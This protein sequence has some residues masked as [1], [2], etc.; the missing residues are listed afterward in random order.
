MILS[1]AGGMLG[2]AIGLT[3]AG[4][5]F[6]LGVMLA[7]AGAIVNA[8]VDHK[9]AVLAEI[10]GEREDL[11]IGFKS[12]WEELD[13]VRANTTPAATVPV[14]AAT[15]VEPGPSPLNG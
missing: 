9:N 7:I 14:Y 1:V 8:I 10:R 11:R 13:R 2:F 12:L 5:L 3:M 15:P 4:G 6:S